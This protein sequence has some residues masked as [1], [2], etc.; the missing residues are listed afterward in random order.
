MTTLVLLGML[1]AACPCAAHN[2][3]PFEVSVLEKKHAESIAKAER[4]YIKALE[5]LKTRFMKRGDLDAANLVARMIGDA[6]ALGSG[7]G[8]LC[9]IRVTASTTASAHTLVKNAPRLSG[10]YRPAFSFV[11]KAI[12][13]A[14]FTR[15]P[16]RSRPSFKVEVERSGYLYLTGVSRNTF[17]EAGLS[18]AEVP[19]RIGGSYVGKLYAVHVTAG[20]SFECGGYES[21]L[22]A[23]G[24]TIE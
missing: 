2:P 20:Q 14:Q 22:I 18:V 24:I 1:S 12:E 7:L 16:W 23:S 6:K 15:V 5:K 9:Q 19:D 8:D 13:G 11:S 21:C 17:S 3:P 4:E 10:G